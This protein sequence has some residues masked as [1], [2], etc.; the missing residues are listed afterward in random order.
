MWLCWRCVILSNYPRITPAYLW[1]AMLSNIMAVDS[2]TMSP[3]S[4]MFS[5]IN[6]LSHGVLLQQLKSNRHTQVSCAGSQSHKDL[7]YAHLLVLLDSRGLFLAWVGLR[8][9]VCAV[10]GWGPG[11]RSMLSFIPYPAWD[12]SSSGT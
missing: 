11:L 10:I 3:Q 4:K 1:P 7:V 12:F 9:G 8:G 5:F 2:G 6:C